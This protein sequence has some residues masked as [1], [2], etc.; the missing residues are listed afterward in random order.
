M[1]LKCIRKSNRALRSEQGL[2]F[3]FIRLHQRKEVIPLKDYIT[4]Q[5]LV[6]H[7]PDPNLRTPEGNVKYAVNIDIDGWSEVLEELNK[8][9]PEFMCLSN[10]DALSHLKR[11][12]LGINLPQIYLKVIISSKKNMH[13]PI[14]CIGRRSLDWRPRGK[15]ANEGYQHQSRAQGQPL[16]YDRS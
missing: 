7:N 16:V 6:A 2:I 3:L 8:L 1:D 9:P 14:I 15:S 4:Y 11:K 10:K 12:V 13:N 5:Y